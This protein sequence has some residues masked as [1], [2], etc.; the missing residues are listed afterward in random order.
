M[1]ELGFEGGDSGGIRK[2]LG[3]KLGFRAHTLANH[4]STLGKSDAKK[5]RMKH[6]L[7]DKFQL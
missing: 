4:S 2:E 3:K 7:E 1:K 5:F 6:I